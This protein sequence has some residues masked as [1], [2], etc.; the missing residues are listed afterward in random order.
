MP[1]QNDYQIL[2]FI[3]QTGTK[4][5]IPRKDWL[6]FLHQIIDWS[7]PE[8]V[9][10]RKR[11]ASLPTEESRAI[12]QAVNEWR[13]KAQLKPLK[14]PTQLMFQVEIAHLAKLKAFQLSQKMA[15]SGSPREKK[16]WVL[17]SLSSGFFLNLSKKTFLGDECLDRIL[18]L[19]ERKVKT[20]LFGK[21]IQELYRNEDIYLDLDPEDLFTP[22]RVLVEISKQLA[23][24]PGDR[25]VDLGSGLGR[26]GIVLGLLN[27]KI[28]FI[29]LELMKERHLQAE[30][31]SKNLGLNQRIKFEC[32]DL[33]K[34][35]IPQAE[36]YYLFNPFSYLTLQR[37]FR[38]L[39]ENSKSK[40]FKV[41][42]AQVGRPPR[43]VKRQPW[44]QQTY[45]SPLDRNWRA[46]GFSMYQSREPRS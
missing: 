8:K 14:K 23:L 15:K 3:T 21:N 32:C 9:T 10:L 24:H 28:K 13:K 33:S 25:L 12:F 7:F 42:M 36:S 41:L 43:M 26:V 18:G 17:R 1:V 16:N 44:L 37:V 27:P 38:S 2:K 39:Y 11:I 31:A 6:N 45:L 40:Q 30:Q 5:S 19:N 22:Y 46:H 20:E 34:I 35:K 4:I 29:G